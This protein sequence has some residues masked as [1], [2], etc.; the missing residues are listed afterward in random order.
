MSLCNGLCN[1]CRNLIKVIDSNTIECEAYLFSVKCKAY[2][3][4]VK[5]KSEC[6]GYLS[7]KCKNEKQIQKNNNIIADMYLEDE[8]KRMYV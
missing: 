2:L 7:Y 3:F 4:S 6:R 8:E 5:C 1:D